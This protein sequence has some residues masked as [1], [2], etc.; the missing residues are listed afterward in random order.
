MGERIIPS[1][2]SLVKYDNPVLL[3]KHQEKK[4]VGKMTMTRPCS[5][6]RG[7]QDK[8]TKE[9][10]NAILPPREWEEDGNRWLQQVRRGLLL[11]SFELV[12]R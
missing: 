11:A 12:A 5:P 2:N 10:L 7:E 9:I 1:A 3:T 6:T 4:Q 8:E